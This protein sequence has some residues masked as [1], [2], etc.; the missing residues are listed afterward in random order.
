M[1]RSRAPRESSRLA[2]ARLLFRVFVVTAQLGPVA[3]LATHRNDHT[4]GPE[5]A[6]A[7]NAAH[8]VAHRLGRPHD[9]ADAGEDLTA[10][11]RAWLAG[12]EAPTPDSSGSRH[13][14]GRESAAHFGLALLQGPPPPLVPPPSATIAPPPDT[15]PR[16]Y[17]RPTPL[18]PP[19][20]GPPA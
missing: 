20:R 4:H 6:S 12:D 3:H 2:A 5:F 9:H 19:T 14:H 17:A 15:A 10:E 1:G 16:R 8:E 13:D 11:E 7:G 18:Q